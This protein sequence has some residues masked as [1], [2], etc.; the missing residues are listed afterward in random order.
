MSVQ[1]KVSYER[2]EELKAI[3]EKLKPEVKSWKVA[4][5]QEGRFL[6]AYIEMVE[7]RGKPEETT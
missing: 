3:L 6:R 4:K 7:P 2:P 5:R 1:I